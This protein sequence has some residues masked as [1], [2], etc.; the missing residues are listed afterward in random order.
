MTVGWTTLGACA[1]LASNGAWI[2]GSTL[3]SRVLKEASPFGINLGRGLLTLAYLGLVLLLVGWPAI[4]WRAFLMLGGSGLL[5]MAVGDTLFFAALARLGPRLT[6]LIGMSGPLFSIALGVGLLQETISPTGWWGI[7]LTVAGV[8]GV[9]LPTAGDSANPPRAGRTLGIGCALLASLC[10]ACASVLAKQAL[11]SVS[12]LQAAFVRML[13][14]VAALALVG[15]LSGR[16]GTWLSPFRDPHK[17]R[18]IHG[19]VLVVVFGG[20]FLSMVALQCLP[21]STMAVL[22]ATEPLLALAVTA[23]M[24]GQPIRP[25]ELL[26][27]LL[28]LVGVV[29]L[30]RGA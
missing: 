6:I 2:V 11:A 12:P 13:W 25:R 28:G 5:G 7:A 1:A 23:V 9:L 27:V 26:S 4:T 24:L 16:L 17:L 21:V 14:S 22:I 30:L 19:A 18:Q 10:M 29:L 20:F 8:L 3:F 15:G